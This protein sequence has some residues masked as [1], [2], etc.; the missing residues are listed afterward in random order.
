[1]EL[2]ALIRGK[3]ELEDDLDTWSGNLKDWQGTLDQTHAN[4]LKAIDLI[5]KVYQDSE[6]GSDIE[7]WSNEAYSLL[8]DIREELGDLASGDRL[9]RMSL[10]IQ[11]WLGR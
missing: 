5:E 10:E 1:M 3:G 9:N 6:D 7:E 2:G 11:G 4:L 8:D